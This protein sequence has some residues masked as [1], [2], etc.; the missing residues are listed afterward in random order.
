MARNNS[1]IQKSY[2]ELDF[3]I[4]VTGV[5]AGGMEAKQEFFS[6]MPDA[7]KH[8]SVVFARHPGPS[9]KPSCFN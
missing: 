1:T 2:S 7:L 4:A 8:V 6:K 5:P 3:Y 9:R